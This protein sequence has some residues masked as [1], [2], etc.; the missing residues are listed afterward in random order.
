[1]IGLRGLGDDDVFDVGDLMDGEVGLLWG[2]DD[3]PGAQRSHLA[4]S[5]ERLGCI[6]S[7]NAG[8]NNLCDDLG[9]AIG[10]ALW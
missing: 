4:L 2:I 7:A 3:R 1:M 8:F 10:R 5:P 9:V 6:G